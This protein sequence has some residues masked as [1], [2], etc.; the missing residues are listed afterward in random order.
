MLP[1]CR[2]C[3]KTIACCCVV[4]LLLRLSFSSWTHLECCPRS[5]TD[6]PVF[7][8]VVQTLWTGWPRSMLCW[9]ACYIAGPSDPQL[10][11]QYHACQS[12]AIVSVRGHLV[13]CSHGRF[14]QKSIP[15]CP[16]D[17]CFQKFTHRC[18]PQDCLLLKHAECGGT[19]EAC[20]THALAGMGCAAEEAWK[21]NFREICSSEPT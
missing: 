6:T 4:V 18:W 12:F 13:C 14:F 5:T 1:R 15:A 9:V 10:F 3:A 16:H 11:I 19:M 7:T 20:L 8:E 17:H 2:R 21:Q